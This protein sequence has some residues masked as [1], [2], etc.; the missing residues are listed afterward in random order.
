M[1]IYFW[2]LQTREIVQ[3]LEGHRGQSTLHALATA[4]CVNLLYHRRGDRSSRM[5]SHYLPLSVR[6]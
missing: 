6:F 5:A 2:D 3:V 1:K 4:Y